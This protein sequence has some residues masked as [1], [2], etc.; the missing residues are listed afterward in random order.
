MCVC[1]VNATILLHEMLKYT[2]LSYFSFEFASN[3]NVCAQRFYNGENVNRE[4]KSL[5]LLHVGDA[6]GIRIAEC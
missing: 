6:S 4:D 1:S 2:V 3:R 5:A